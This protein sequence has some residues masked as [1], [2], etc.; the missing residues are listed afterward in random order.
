M[1]PGYSGMGAGFSAALRAF[2]SK[3]AHTAALSKSSPNL[4]AVMGFALSGVR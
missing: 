2:C 4:R 3:T 1:L